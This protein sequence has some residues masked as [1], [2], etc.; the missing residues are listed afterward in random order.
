MR[1]LIRARR[2]ELGYS[3][4][5]LAEALGGT[6]QNTILNVERGWAREPGEDYTPQRGTIVKLAE[7]LD[8]D[9]ERMLRAYGHRAGPMRRVVDVT[10]LT[11]VQI[12]QVEAFVAGLRQ[13]NAE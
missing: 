10:G 13:Q 4:R 5:E 7:V 11:P 12:G 6:S 8:I 9:E 1:N 3:R 2:E